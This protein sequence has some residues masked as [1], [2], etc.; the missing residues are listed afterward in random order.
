M[1]QDV[2]N[3]RYAVDEYIFGTE[4]SDILSK[5]SDLFQSGERALAIADGEGRNGVYLAS[6]GLQVTSFDISEVA[7]QKA[8]K[9]AAQQRVELTILESDIE[10]W[11]WESAAFDAVIGVFFQF[12]DPAARADA[13][14]GMMTTLKPGGLVFLRGYTPK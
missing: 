1:K 3:R 10:S 6:L 11:H 7:I 14:A 13:F 4:P 2:W 9:L 12:L 5:N 8:K